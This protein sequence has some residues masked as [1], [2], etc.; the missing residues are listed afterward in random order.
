MNNL[1]FSIQHF[2]RAPNVYQNLDVSGR[3]T[4]IYD[5]K[6][7]TIIKFTSYMGNLEIVKK[8]EK[9]RKSLKFPI[10]NLKSRKFFN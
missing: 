1:Q 9:P 3:I 5:V 7:F 10:K 4:F 6:N 8:N 2:P